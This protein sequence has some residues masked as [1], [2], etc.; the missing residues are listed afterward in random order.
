[1]KNRT[2]G[3]SLV[4]LL[5]VSAMT[6]GMCLTLAYVVRMGLRSWQT[7]SNR[8]TVSFELRRGLNAMSRELV[9]TRASLLQVPGLGSMPADGNFYSGV[10]FPIP[11]DVDGD[12]TVLNGSGVLEW[13]PNLITYS[14]GGLDGRQVRRTQGGAVSVL[15]HGVTS[16]Q[17]RRLVATPYIVEMRVRVQRGSATGGFIN[18]A[19]L[20]TQI[21]LRN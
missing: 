3:F 19:D 18:Q 1:M 6:V 2:R 16:L 12:G 14:L 13:S 10:Q 4:E 21:R 15:A 8:M 5:V 17:F 9:Q 20:S 7:T 11:Q